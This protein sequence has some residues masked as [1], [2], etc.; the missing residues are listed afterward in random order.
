MLNLCEFGLP[1]MAKLSNRCI[2]FGETHQG[3]PRGMLLSCFFMESFNSFQHLHSWSSIYAWRS[4]QVSHH[5][6]F[7]SWKVCSPFHGYK[8]F[9]L[10]SHTFHGSEFRHILAGPSAQGLMRLPTRCW[11]GYTPSGAWDSLLYSHSC[12]HSE[13]CNWRPWG[14]C[15]LADCPWG[16][17]SALG[18]IPLLF[19]TGHLTAW[20]LTSPRHY[21][22]GVC[23]S[24]FLSIFFFAI[25]SRCILDFHILFPLSLNSF[26]YFSIS[27]PL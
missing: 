8:S 6:Y 22:S 9:D 14:P 16:P 25:P 11:P 18:G 2:D 13:P 26:Y 7:H 23:I 15:F 21:F 12:Q 5:S 24:I 10:L 19:A 3:V 1:F 17:L 4:P 27:L 20:Q